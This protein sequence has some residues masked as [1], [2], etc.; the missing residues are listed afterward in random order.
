MCG[1]SIADL[2]AHAV[3]PECAYPVDASIDA[4]LRFDRSIPKPRVL[5]AL[6]AGIALIQA[7]VLLGCGAAL[8]AVPSGPNTWAEGLLIFAIVGAGICI[9]A[10]WCA[11]VATTSIARAPRVSKTIAITSATSALCIIVATFFLFS[12][13]LILALPAFATLALSASIG[14][15]AKVIFMESIAE[16]FPKRMR[17]RLVRLNQVAFIAFFAS[18]GCVLLSLLL[19]PFAF[20]A[21]LGVV[22]AGWRSFEFGRRI[23]AAN[24]KPLH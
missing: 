21:P 10:A 20:L 2:S 9:E 23:R 6:L 12:E 15:T 22:A 17:D 24:A 3:C 16:L 14:A 1:F 8:L 7:C 11:I 19:F 13:A 4:R 5:A 18:V